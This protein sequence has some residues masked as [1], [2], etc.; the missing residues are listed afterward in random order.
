[1]ARSAVLRP[2]LYAEGGIVARVLCVCCTSFYIP[3]ICQLCR[4]ICSTLNKVRS[5]PPLPFFGFFLFFFYP[6]FFCFRLISPSPFYSPPPL[7]RIRLELMGAP[8]IPFFS[9]C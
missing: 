4:F 6:F 5:R 1:M 9:A 2:E 7:D 8:D 3:H